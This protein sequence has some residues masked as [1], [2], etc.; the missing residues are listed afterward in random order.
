MIG[1]FGGLL[2]FDAVGLHLGVKYQNATCYSEQAIMS[3]STWLIMVCTL[4]IFMFLLAFCMY[5]F[6][7]K[8]YCFAC[9][10]LTLIAILYLTSFVMYIIGIIE[11]AYQFPGC[12]NEVKSVCIMTIIILIVNIMAKIGFGNYGKTYG[13]DGYEQV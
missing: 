1:L 10:G 13:R 3:L 6:S 5:V 7:L 2:A 4:A 9:S 12:K 8:N 11:L